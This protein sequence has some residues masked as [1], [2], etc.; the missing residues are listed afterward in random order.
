MFFSAR[1]AALRVRGLRIV[2]FGV[3]GELGGDAGS[4]A[5]ARGRGAPRAKVTPTFGLTSRRDHIATLEAV[6]GRHYVRQF[7]AC[8]PSGRPA[9][10]RTRGCP[11]SER[12]DRDAEAEVRRRKRLHPGFSE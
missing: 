7:S 9:G 12:S 10:A 2:A 4:G 5:L 1:L 3:N 6:R 11:A 8:Q